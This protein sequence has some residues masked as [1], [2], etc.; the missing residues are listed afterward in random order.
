MYQLI[1][2][3]L[4]YKHL[5]FEELFRMLEIARGFNYTHNIT[6]IL[7]Y[8]GRTFWQLLEGEKEDVEL[9]Y[10]SIIEPHRHHHSSQV[11]IEI[12]GGERIF[13]EWK[14]G[15]YHMKMF[16]KMMVP[17]LISANMIDLRLMLEYRP[18]KIKN[19]F[20]SVLNNFGEDMQNL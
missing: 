4:S 5:E 8:D 3:S 14:M 20:L 1:Y 16:D 9:L 6:G 17:G 2:K 13:P 19:F 10:Q 11:L 18:N 7:L 12:E 15:F